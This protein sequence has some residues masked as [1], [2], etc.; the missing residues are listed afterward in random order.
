MAGEDWAMV[1]L[2]YGGELEVDVMKALKLNSAT[3]KAWKGW[4]V[5]PRTGAKELFA[6][7]S[8]TSGEAGKTLRA[9]SPS[10]GSKKD[11]W[12]LLLLAVP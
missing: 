5:D 12:L 6:S 4:W 3:G 7:G 2:P 9:S 11:D 1:H 8:N 10:Q